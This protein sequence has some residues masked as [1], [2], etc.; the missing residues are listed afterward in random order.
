M[1]L[2]SRLRRR[3]GSRTSLFVLYISADDIASGV[4]DDIRYE[5]IKDRVYDGL[6]LSKASIFEK[7]L[8][9]NES[10]LATF[11]N[12]AARPLD[13]CLPILFYKEILCVEK[14][15]LASVTDSKGTV[16]P[17]VAASEQEVTEPPNA[18]AL[19]VPEDEATEPEETAETA[20]TAEIAPE[21]STS[22]AEQSAESLR[23]SPSTK[24]T[25]ISGSSRRSTV[26]FSGTKGT[27]TECQVSEVNLSS[28]VNGQY[29]TIGPQEMVRGG[30]GKR[31]MGLGWRW[32]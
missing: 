23:P 24:I 11:L 29:F 1:A 4:M 21:A 25:P 8:E 15:T 19:A 10:G 9:A 31:M 5:W 6:G 2:S 32:E 26:F 28:A 22:M 16:A 13:E 17:E 12:K 27:E 30:G 18:T 20:E 3:S 14:Q 7:F